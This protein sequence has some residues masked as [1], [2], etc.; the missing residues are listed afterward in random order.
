MRLILLVVLLLSGC[1]YSAVGSFA[2][3]PDNMSGNQLN[4]Q[5]RPEVV[6]GQEANK[7]DLL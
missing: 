4:Q 5:I 3:V 2:I 1:G 6:A 7:E